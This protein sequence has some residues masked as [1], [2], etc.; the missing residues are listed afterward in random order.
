MNDNESSDSVKK[1]YKI[2]IVD[3]DREILNSLKLVLRSADEFESDISVASNG[4]MALAKLDKK[5]FDL[6]LADYKMP[7]MNGIELLSRVKR[8]YPKT[9]RILITA[10]SD[11]NVA[12]KSIES[13]QVHNYIE[14]PADID[15]LRLTIHEALKRKYER[16]SIKRESV[17]NVN[18]ALELVDN[19]LKDITVIPA[20]HISKQLIMLEFNSVTEFNKFSFALRNMKN[21]Q[22]V[23]FQ[24][25]E[26]KHLI[27]IV[28]HPDKFAIIPKF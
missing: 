27:S 3:D 28:V 24:I 16:E 1:I 11:M 8:K 12:K 14:K 21:T 26:D 5:E 23:D 19:L 13:A 20:E 6:V 9:V 25:F 15:E 2:L 22:I 17:N 10:Y 4:Q 7:G 18:E